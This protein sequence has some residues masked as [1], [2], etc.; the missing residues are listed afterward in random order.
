MAEII[1]K[2]LK[3]GISACAFG[4][5]V[6]YNGRALDALSLLGR[7]RSDFSV[8]P[9]CPECLAGLGVPVI[10]VGAHY[11]NSIDDLAARSGVASPH[12]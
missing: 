3:V 5:P 6:R 8:T 10:L 2:R 4:C 7:E 11:T 9:V 12:A 1:S